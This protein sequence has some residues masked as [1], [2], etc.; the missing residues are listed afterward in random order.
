MNTKGK[1]GLTEW[2]VNDHR[3]LEQ[4]FTLDHPPARKK[5][6][7]ND[8]R[9]VLQ[10]DLRGNLHGNLHADNETIEFISPGGVG[11]VHYGQ[12]HAFDAAGREL[13][14]TMA[15]NGSSL[16]IRVDAQ[17]ARYP[18]TID[19]MATSPAW[20]AESDQA[21]AWFGG[22]V[23]TAGDVNGDGYADV[24]VA[25][26]NYDNSQAYE[27]RAYVY[28]GS[29]SGLS[30]VHAWTAESDQTDASFGNSMSTAGD[31][32]GDGYAD[33]IIGA[34][35]YDNGQTD[36]G[37]AYVYLGSASGLATISFIPLLLLDE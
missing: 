8:S 10:M 13:P 24:I 5:N 2:Y 22:S 27:Y 34:Y 15:L 30:A 29:A 35:N 7:C 25:A 17:D 36:E 6:G 28:L 18:L 14:V 33:V 12:L 26:Y 3:G 21:Y 9:I 20:S 37:R 31:V 16:E 11:G 1:T 19:P 4:G 32:N 23:S